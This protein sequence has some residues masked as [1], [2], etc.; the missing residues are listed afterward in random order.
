MTNDAHARREYEVR[1]RLEALGY[2]LERNPADGCDYKIV[3]ARPDCKQEHENLKRSWTL[4]AVENCS[5]YLEEMER[6]AHLQEVFD[7]ARVF[8]K[9]GGTRGDWLLEFDLAEDLPDGTAI[10]ISPL[11]HQ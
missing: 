9:S 6:E 7:R 8:I 3:C 2:R 11:T 4:E 10:Q 5:C 1:L